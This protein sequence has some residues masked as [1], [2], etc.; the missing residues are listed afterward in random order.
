VT[1]LL[2]TLPALLE[3]LLSED[4]LTAPQTDC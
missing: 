2:R 4:R 1:T 3:P